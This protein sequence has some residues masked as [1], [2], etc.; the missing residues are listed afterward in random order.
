MVPVKQRS[1]L[2]PWNLRDI[3]RAL[4]TEAP[5]IE[6]VYLFGSRAYNTG[7]FRSD[8]DL[9][10]R[11]SEP[12]RQASLTGWVH[13]N[14][15]PVDL[16]E[17]LD[18]RVA[19][20]LMNGSAVMAK[21]GDLV[22]QLDARLLWRRDAGFDGEFQMWDQFTV[23]GINFAMTVLPL[24]P[25]IVELAG[26]FTRRLSDEGYPSVF[27]GSDW[28]SIGWSLAEIVGKALDTPSRFGAR[29]KHIA[30]ATLRIADEYDFQNLIHL[31]L[32]PWLPSIESENTATRYDGQDKRADFG[33]ER[34]AI[35][36]EAKHVRNDTDKRAVLKDLEGLKDFYRRNPNVRLLLFL[37]LIDPSVDFN[38]HLV[39]DDFSDTSHTPVVLVRVYTNT[40]APSSAG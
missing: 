9:L 15:P 7:S 24:A 29:A 18:M 31:V 26:N 16:F 40:L 34:N 4:V 22:A 33:I 14:F 10:V 5:E 30:T 38:R 28:A 2:K 35:I 8:I 25:N 19:R 3:I 11:A 36:I 27:L 21:T 37:V 1:D 23:T 20:S 6:E 17:T 32:R 39:E 13:E 12:L